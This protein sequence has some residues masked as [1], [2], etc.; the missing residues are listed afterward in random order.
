VF[1]G[2]EGFLA[3]LP[4]PLAMRSGTSNPTNSVKEWGGVKVRQEGSS[5][6]I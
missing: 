2:G 5:D 1:L 6:Q 4:A 3:L